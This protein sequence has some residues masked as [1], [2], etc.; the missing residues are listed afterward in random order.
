M[1]AVAVPILEV[2]TRKLKPN[3]AFFLIL[4]ISSAF[5]FQTP[6]F[7]KMLLN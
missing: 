2:L 4:S 7:G 5:A 1:K 3:L 6:D